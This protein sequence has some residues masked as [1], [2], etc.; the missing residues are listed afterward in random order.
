MVEEWKD[1]R[2]EMKRVIRK[3]K[4][5]AWN[6]WLEKAE[7]PR[8]RDVLRGTSAALKTLQI[9]RIMGDDGRV[10]ENDQ[11]KRDIL[12]ISHSLRRIHLMDV[13]IAMRRTS[14]HGI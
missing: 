13:C 14:L 5:A 10:S 1:S 2:R 4:R 7:G 12:E 11:D 8:V 3:A 6:S 9:G